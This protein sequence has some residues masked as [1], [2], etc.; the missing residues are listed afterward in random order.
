MTLRGDRHKITVY[1]PTAVIRSLKLRAVEEETYVST[2]I[3]KAIDH[4]YSPSV[5]VIEHNGQQR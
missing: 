1:L 4:A 5:R 3:E 2:L